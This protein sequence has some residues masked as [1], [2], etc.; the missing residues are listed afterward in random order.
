[1]PSKSRHVRR[2]VDTKVN[3][4][5]QNICSVDDAD[6]WCEHSL[7][8]YK[9]IDIL[10]IAYFVACQEIL[11]VY[12]PQYKV[13]ILRWATQKPVFP[14]QF[15]EFWAEILTRDLNRISPELQ[16]KTQKKTFFLRTIRPISRL[17]F[18]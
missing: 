17:E 10:T 1:M 4:K 6:T 14:A 15:Y 7:R 8:Q 18:F 12:D 16:A 9:T 2:Y 3:T 5:C 11:R 13:K